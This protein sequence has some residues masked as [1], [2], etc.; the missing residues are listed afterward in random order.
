[1]QRLVELEERVQHQ[2]FPCG[3]E[4]CLASVPFR[5][6]GHHRY[7][8]CPQRPCGC[9]RFASR[10]SNQHHESTCQSS[11]T[12]CLISGCEWNG[13]RK[14]LPAHAKS[15]H[16]NDILWV[17]PGDTTSS[18]TSSSSTHETVVRIHPTRPMS[19]HTVAGVLSLRTKKV[20][21]E[22]DG[23]MV[24]LAFRKVD[25]VMQQCMPI[26]LFA[27]P[28]TDVQVEMRVSW[29]NPGA[30]QNVQGIYTGPLVHWH[31][32]RL[33]PYTHLPDD[34]NITGIVMPVRKMYTIHKETNPGPIEPF[35]VSFNLKQMTIC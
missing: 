8:T 35:Q 19:L 6:L 25:H 12:C 34:D 3:N 11:T 32:D 31:P 27:P 18:S 29:V 17:G 16:S 24:M 23:I 10:S 33:D 2:S 4:G 26:L 21:Y 20:V 13:P 9:N 7:I 1:M 15:A 14:D 5:K 28:F 30:T 22:D